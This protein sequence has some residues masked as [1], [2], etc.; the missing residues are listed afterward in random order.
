MMPLK[1]WAEARARPDEPHD[2]GA[3]GHGASWARGPAFLNE[4]PPQKK[5]S[6]THHIQAHTHRIPHQ[7]PTRLNPEP[8]GTTPK[9]V[10][11]FLPK[12][13]PAFKHFADDG[14]FRSGY[15]NFQNTVC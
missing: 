9:Q 6:T 1:A 10:K 14:S 12:D 5:R 7:V 4:V 8:F 13:G 3:S 11:N 2:W 15:S